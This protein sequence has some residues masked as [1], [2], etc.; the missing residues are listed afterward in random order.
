MLAS[1]L[2]NQRAPDE[3]SSSSPLSQMLR[4]DVGWTIFICWLGMGP[5]QPL[6]RLDQ[7]FG[8]VP[9]EAVI[10]CFSAGVQATES[11]VES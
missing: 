8:G 1:L 11:A 3:N 9:P 10:P 6:L 2:G 4:T 7:T 5:S